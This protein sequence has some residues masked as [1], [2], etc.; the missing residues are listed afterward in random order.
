MIPAEPAKAAPSG[1]LDFLDWTRGLAVAI[2][3]QGHVFDSFSRKDLRTQGAFVL[4]QFLGG[5]APALFLVLTGITLGF[6]MHR[7]QQADISPMQRWVRALRRAGYLFLLAILFRLQLWI[8][9]LG[10]SPWTDLFRV[11][12]LNCMGLS[13][14][15]MSVLALCTTE[16]RARYGAILG[17]S[18]AFASPVVSSL[19]W[20]WLPS[21]IANYVA[22]S[23]VYFALFPWAAFIAFGI[24]IGSLLRMVEAPDVNRLMQWG[25]L[26]GF[27]M[28]IGGQYFANLP[29]SIYPKSEFWLD[30]PTQVCVKLGVVLLVLGAAYVWTGHLNKSRWSWM[31]Q[32]GTT[33]LLVYWVHIELVYGRWFGSYKETLSTPQVVGSCIALIV[34]MI[35]LSLLQTRWRKAGW[36]GLAPHRVKLA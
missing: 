16:E 2:I 29:Y 18:I 21:P 23:Y 9:A 5:L 6:L 14:A 25:S 1:R 7:N 33:S 28:V 26:A 12:V 11:D 3:L 20:T 36:A 8:F 35:G 4:S 22:P 15:L 19:D 32:L 24:S 30:S 17:I 27:A 34:S 13:I 31:R 10:A